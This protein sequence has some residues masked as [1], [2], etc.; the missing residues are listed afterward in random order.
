MSTLKTL[1]IMGVAGCGKSLIGS[2]L[3]K[4]IDGIFEDGD[5]FH[6][7]ENKAKM[8]AGTPLNDDDRQP[9]LEA[10]RRRM[11]EVRKLHPDSIFVV[12]C[13]SLKQKYRDT[14]R[15]EDDEETLKFVY[16]KGSKELIAA[17]MGSRKGHFMPTSLLES[18]FN[19]LEEPINAVV[20]DISKTPEEVVEN[21]AKELNL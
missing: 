13:S 14:L 17:R 9:W 10:I 2:L 4:R 16:L 12:G 1:V 11:L 5:D 21:I 18:Q 7:A 19:T 15:G 8:S 6:P 3:A 20:V